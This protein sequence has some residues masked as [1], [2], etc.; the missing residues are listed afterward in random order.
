MQDKAA[1]LA[2]Q[3]RAG[4]GG[5]RPLGC[6]QPSFRSSGQRRPLD[7]A[8]GPVADR[9]AMLA[10]D[11]VR[12][13]PEQPIHLYDLPPADDA[14]RTVQQRLD[15]AERGKQLRRDHDA[16]GRRGEVDQRAIHVEQQ[17]RSRERRQGWS[18]WHWITR[19]S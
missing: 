6:G 1:R 14:Q 4:M 16:L 2:L 19:T 5:G 15:P 13:V 8:A 17:G 10:R 11:G 3:P 7:R 9:A 18:Y 12:R